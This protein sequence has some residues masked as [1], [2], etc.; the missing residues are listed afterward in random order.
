MTWAGASYE[1]E[2]RGWGGWVSGAGW[3]ASCMTLLPRVLLNEEL[4]WDNPVDPVALSFQVGSRAASLMLRPLGL[5][6]WTRTE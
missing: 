1:V 3:Q 5:A 4:G 2:G 6:Q